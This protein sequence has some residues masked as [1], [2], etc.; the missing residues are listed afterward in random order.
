MDKH[1][2]GEMP[3][4]TPCDRTPMLDNRSFHPQA[5]AAFKLARNLPLEQRQY[6]LRVLEEQT[7]ALNADGLAA[8]QA[9]VAHGVR[10]FLNTGEATIRQY[11]SWRER[12]PD[13]DDLPT[14]KQV[15]DAFGGWNAA[16]AAA[17]SGEPVNA[18]RRRNVVGPAFMQCEIDAAV[19][20]YAKR[21]LGPLYLA[22]YEKW[23]RELMQRAGESGQPFDVTVIVRLPNGEEDEVRLTR[24]PLGSRSLRGWDAALDRLGLADRS[25]RKHRRSINPPVKASE[26]ALTAAL[27]EACADLGQLPTF[28]GYE[29]WADEQLKRGRLVPLASTIRTHFG[30]WSNA[31]LSAGLINEA[32]VARQAQAGKRFDYDY[33]VEVMRRALAVY[34]PAMTRPQYNAWRDEQV[35]AGAP[36]PPSDMTLR[37]YL[38]NLSW[39]KAIDVVLNGEGLSDVA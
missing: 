3:A 34:G 2:P 20:L 31:L 8:R 28:P 4:S 37:K 18:A 35:A 32:A 33:L 36:A 11:V 22:E 30:N 21:F 26:E 7:S 39:R 19:T 15:L 29:T 38:G 9:Y 17:N 23:A 6:L 24:L 16:K 14:R 27:K 13:V 12:Q 25:G 10:R 1:P 5:K